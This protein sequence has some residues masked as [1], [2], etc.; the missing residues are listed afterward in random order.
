M[1]VQLWHSLGMKKRAC[2]T[3][4]L[5]LPLDRY[6]KQASRKDGLQS[7]CKGCMKQRTT[8]YHRA[9]RE[10]L[11]PR[12]NAVITRRRT[13]NPVKALLACARTRAKFAGID[14]TI[15]EADLAFPDVCPVLGEPLQFGLGKGESMSLAVRDW[16][17]SIDR[18]D[19]Q[20][21]Y[22]PGNVIVV[23]YRANRLKSDANLEELR[24]LV[25]FY[26]QLEAN[27]GGQ[28]ALP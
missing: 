25:K 27:E 1:T 24:K 11:R 22:V 6:W 20:L 17:Y 15:T 23:S 9:N 12:N 7:E 28:T 13:S 26:E 19:N 14:F 21:G 3:C 2:R 10:R 8:A 5:E 16:R 4:K 18:I